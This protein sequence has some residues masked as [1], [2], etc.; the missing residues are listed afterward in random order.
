SDISISLIVQSKNIDAYNV[1]YSVVI[2]LVERLAPI[3]EFLQKRWQ[4]IQTHSTQ[5]GGALLICSV[6]YVLWN[7]WR[8]NDRKAVASLE[9]LM[10]DQEPLSAPDEEELEV[11]S[12]PAT[13]PAVHTTSEHST[14]QS[15]V[16]EPTHAQVQAQAS[17]P[18]SNSSTLNTVPP[19][20]EAIASHAGHDYISSLPLE[21]IE[22]ILKFGW[23]R[24]W[25]ERFFLSSCSLVCSRWRSTAQK[26]L[27][28]DI[29][30]STE[31]QAIAFLAAIRSNPSLGKETRIIRL[32][33]DP[34]IV[35]DGEFGSKI[36]QGLLYCITQWCPLTH[37]LDL[38]FD[39]SCDK[40]YAES[41]VALTSLLHPRTF[42]RLQ[43]LKIRIRQSIPKKLRKRHV[44]EIQDFLM[45]FSS[46]SHLHLLDVLLYL[47]MLLP[48][49]YGRPS[50][51]FQLFELGLLEQAYTRQARFISLVHWLLPIRLIG[52]TLQVVHFSHFIT[53]SHKPLDLFSWFMGRYGKGLA[54]LCMIN[55]SHLNSRWEIWFSPLVIPHKWWQRFPS[56]H[57]FLELFSPRP[58]EN[59]PW[60]YEETTL[61]RS[62]VTERIHPGP[63]VSLT[64]TRLNSIKFTDPTQSQPQDS[65]SV[66][67]IMWSLKLLDIPF[68]RDMIRE[69]PFP[70]EISIENFRYMVVAE[71]E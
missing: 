21:L 34:T 13:S 53:L 45:M 48:P 23:D 31:S 10:E 50:P 14:S 54:S 60:S 70:R 29:Q 4:I 69:S 3:G 9:T 1:M 12:D 27:F 17:S 59:D 36:R 46:L 24:D 65:E 37:R 39:D 18:A 16:S 19:Q 44:R 63:R 22:E 7:S 66:W 25:Q 68:D 49:Y 38:Q 43:A 62:L 41:K 52:P 47:D 11:S 15:P 40:T 20:L 55:P 30:L 61:H 35:T 67:N 56:T 58:L 6:T 2:R 57:L 5:S 64:R 26:L 8:R 28:R 51:S 71:T 33:F 42:T 32:S